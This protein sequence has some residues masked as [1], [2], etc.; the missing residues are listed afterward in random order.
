MKSNFVIFLSDEE[1]APYPYEPDSIKVWRKMNLP[2]YNFFETKSASDGCLNFKNHRINNS[3][4]RP[5]RADIQTG[6]DC[7]KHGVF[8][9]DGLAIKEEDVNFINPEKTKTLG[10]YLRENGYNTHYIGKQHF[11]NVSGEDDSNLESHGWSNWKSPEPHGPTS[12]KNA[13]GY[14]RDQGYVEEAMTL[15]PKLQEPYCL[16]ISLLNPHDIVFWTAHEMQYFPVGKLL[17]WFFGIPYIGPETD[18]TLPEKIDFPTDNENLSTKPQAHSQFIEIYKKIISKPFFYWF[19]SNKHRLRRFYYTLIK[20][21]QN[22]FY[23]IFETLQK[24]DSYNNTYFLYT[25]DHG[26]MLGNHGD[27]YQKW[28][29]MYEEAIHVPFYIYHPTQKFQPLPENVLTCHLDIVPTILNLAGISIDSNNISGFK[30][31][32]LA[33]YILNH[34]DWNLLSHRR[35]HFHCYDDVT[36]GNDDY[37]IIIKRTKLF[38]WLGLFRY[39]GVKGPRMIKAQIKST[40]SGI[41]KYAKYTDPDDTTN[42]EE[43]MYDLKNDPLEQNNLVLTPEVFKKIKN[44]LFKQRKRKG[45]LRFRG[46]IR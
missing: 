14:Y 1:A 18:T 46:T 6:V 19:H 20:D 5:S 45:H 29:S 32:N 38:Y 8:C 31:K 13:S 15:I 23:K 27:M 17:A 39:R 37:P 44:R 4:C 22:N 33:P 43:E 21:V 12:M 28:Y 35:I 3:G 7:N 25:A 30:G 2:M 36:N 10:M 41:Y 40:P 26:E 24:L 34:R 42:Y 16:F 11:K 9:T